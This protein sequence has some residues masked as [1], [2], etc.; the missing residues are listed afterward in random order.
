MSTQA[1]KALKA[2]AEFAPLIDAAVAATGRA[3][4]AYEEYVTRPPHPGQTWEDALHGRRMSLEAGP[5]ST[6]AADQLRRQVRASRPSA[7]AA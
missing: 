1:S 3:R 7:D 6:T 5:M 2:L 4:R